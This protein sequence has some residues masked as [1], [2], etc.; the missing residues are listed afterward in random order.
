MAAWTAAYAVGSMARSTRRF[1]SMP[2]S[3][4]ERETLL[5]PTKATPKVGDSKSQDLG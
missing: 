1:H 3:S 2:V 4:A 5:L